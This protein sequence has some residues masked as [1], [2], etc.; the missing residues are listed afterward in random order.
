[1]VTVAAAKPAC[2]VQR[3]SRP[4]TRL[5]LRTPLTGNH[6][7]GLNLLVG[8]AALAA[9]ARGGTTWALAG[10]VLLQGYYILDHCDGDV[11][12]TR[13]LASR[14]GFLFDRGVDV[15][16]HTLLFP[17]LAVAESRRIGAAAPLW[18]GAVAAVAIAAILVVFLRQRLGTA[19]RRPPAVRPT[20]RLRPT[21][22]WLAAGDFSLLVLL[23]VLLDLTRPLLWAAAVGAPLYLL[24]IFLFG[25][26]DPGG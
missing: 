10:A 13:G 1:M 9:L 14:S 26:E 11:A 16:V 2:L 15:L 3:L 5:L 24:A 25:L 12:R 17:A 8:L 19:A 6:V 4:V 18:L 22:Q 7:T 20:S 21:L 23:V